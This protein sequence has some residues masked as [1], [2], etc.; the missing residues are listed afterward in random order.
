MHAKKEEDE[1][2]GISKFG[3]NHK[4]INLGIVGG[5]W[6]TVVLFLVCLTAKQSENKYTSLRRNGLY[7]MIA[8]AAR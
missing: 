8:L 3:E 5:G 1:G 4:A 2:K 7:F 6:L